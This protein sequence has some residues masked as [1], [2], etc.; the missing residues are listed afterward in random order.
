MFANGMRGRQQGS[1]RNQTM[2]NPAD[3][4][5]QA[6]IREDNHMNTASQAIRQMTSINQAI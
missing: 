5:K 4:I 6:L 1:G 3:M 2:M